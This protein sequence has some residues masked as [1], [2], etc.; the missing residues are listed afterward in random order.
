MKFTSKCLLVL[1]FLGVSACSGTSPFLSA[2]SNE[3]Q[4]AQAAENSLRKFEERNDATGTGFAQGF[5][6]NAQAD[7]FTV[8]NLAFDGDNVYQRVTF[9]DGAP[10]DLQARVYANSDTFNDTFG[11]GETAI[12]QFLHRLIAQSSDD[13]NV[14]YAI[15]R[16]GNYVNYG[17]GGFVYE[18]NGA[19]DLPASGQAAYE[20]RYSGMRDFNDTAGLEY[21]SGDVQMAIDFDDF[22]SGEALRG[23]IANRRV[24]DLNGAEVTSQFTDGL[25]VVVFTVG[26]GTLSAD[27]SFAGTLSSFNADLTEVETGTYA[28]VLQGSNA[29]QAVGVVVLEGTTTRTLADGTVVADHSYRETGGFIATRGTED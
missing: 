1:S 19:V 9:S 28:G 18:R 11:A 22:E 5:V 26:P 7:T 6:Y 23:R 8:D 20:G 17:Y 16:T 4:V 2:L 21:A 13:G 25:P 24:F 3:E 27:G 10:I 12:N 14:S 29:E 15:V